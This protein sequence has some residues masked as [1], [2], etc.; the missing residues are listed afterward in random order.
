[1]DCVYEVVDS[2]GE[3]LHYGTAWSCYQF[4]EHA[5]V[6][7]LL[8]IQRVHRSRPRSASLSAEK[9]ASHGSGNDVKPRR[10][11]KKAKARR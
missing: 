2:S 4:C 11:P 1:M 5:D 10:R 7:D 3:Q 6:P 9:G 8:S